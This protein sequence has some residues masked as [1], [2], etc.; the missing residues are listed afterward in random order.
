MRPSRATVLSNHR[1]H[2]GSRHM[3]CSRQS[4]TTLACFGHTCLTRCTWLG[5]G[6]PSSTCRFS[7]S[8]LLLSYLPYLMHRT[9][10]SK[11]MN[12]S[13]CANVFVRAHFSACV[14]VYVCTCTC[15]AVLVGTIISILKA[16]TDFHQSAGSFAR[17]M[18]AH[19]SSLVGV[20]R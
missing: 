15:A 3:R 8:C 14:C 2:T 17:T 7:N 5:P 9:E 18:G 19:T 11:A 20:S 16:M 4:S 10:P 12:A 6:K 1:A 13:F